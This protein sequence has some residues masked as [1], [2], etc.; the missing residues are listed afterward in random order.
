[1][2]RLDR[3]TV[4]GRL[5]RGGALSTVIGPFLVANAG[6]Q[7]GDADRIDEGVDEI[8][9]VSSRSDRSLED[10]SRSAR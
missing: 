6:A 8:I 1:M 3:A 10:L 4:V 2:R 5:L 9:V 7:T